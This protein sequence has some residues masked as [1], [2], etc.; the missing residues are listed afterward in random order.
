MNSDDRI[1]AVVATCVFAGGGALAAVLVVVGGGF[2]PSPRTAA[3]VAQTELAPQAVVGTKEVQLAHN[4][5]FEYEMNDQMV[6]SLIAGVSAHPRLTSWLLTDGLLERFV[7]AVESVAQGVTPRGALETLAPKGDF[8]V[9]DY[10]LDFAIT[11][12]TFRRFDMVT[13]AFSSLDSDGIAAVFHEVEPTIN[14]EFARASWGDSGF[15]QVMQQAFVHLL[16][17]EVQ[18]GPLEVE[19][20]A[21]AYVFAEDRLQALSDV[22]RQL[23]RMGP[24]NARKVQAKLRELACAFGWNDL[25]KPAILRAVDESTPVQMPEPLLIARAEAQEKIAEERATPN[26]DLAQPV[27]AAMLRSL[28]VEAN[29]ESPKPEHEF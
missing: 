19:R 9:Y 6:R 27:Q 21:K 8:F 13:D 16:E 18:D 1:L 11:Q 15:E 2:M 3:E 12:G 14:G 20:R 23:L 4:N 29:R 28:N 24:E 10:K 22:Q 26:S 25:E 7:E 17:V 5:N